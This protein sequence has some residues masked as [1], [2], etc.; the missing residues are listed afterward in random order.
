MSGEQLNNDS[1][2][3]LLGNYL[4]AE[5]LK[6]EKGKLVCIAVESGIS[7]NE[8]YMTLGVE[9]NGKKKVWDLNMTNRV[10]LKTAGLAKPSDAKGKFILYRKVTVMN[11]STKKEVESLR[12]TGLEDPNKVPAEVQASA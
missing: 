2:D 4:K 9:V 3:G 11:P 6:D 8:P 5:D 12:I 7:D 10:A 1:W